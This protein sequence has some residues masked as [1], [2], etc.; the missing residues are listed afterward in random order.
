[1]RMGAIFEAMRKSHAQ[2]AF[3]AV[4]AQCPN[5]NPKKNFCSFFGAKAQLLV[6]RSL[7]LFCLTP[8]IPHKLWVGIRA[9][10]R[11]C[12]KC[13]LRM[14]FAHG[15]IKWLPGANACSDQVQNLFAAAKLSFLQLL[16][17]CDIS[18]I[19]LSMQNWPCTHVISSCASVCATINLKICVHL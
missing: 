14:A 9:L 16:F 8:I 3:S 18:Q 19:T 1:M 2:C 5:S 15:L 7:R 4:S 13:A 11:H 17:P 10:R 12:R 6:I